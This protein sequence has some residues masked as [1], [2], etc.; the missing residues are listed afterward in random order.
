MTIHKAVYSSVAES[1][2]RMLDDIYAWLD[3]YELDENLCQ[4]ICLAVSEAFTNALTHANNYDPKKKISISLSIN[5]SSVTA[6]IID[7]GKGGLERIRNH[8]PPEDL[9][10]HGRGLDLIRHYSNSLVL[11]ETERGGTHMTIVFEREKKKEDGTENETNQ[12]EKIVYENLAQTAQEK[13]LILQFVDCN[14]QK[15]GR[16]R[17]LR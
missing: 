2:S 12:L 1:E 16:T 15:R 10:D 14:V 5:E 8:K 6:D 13:D 3:E 11:A 17:C 4:H 9:A 7:E